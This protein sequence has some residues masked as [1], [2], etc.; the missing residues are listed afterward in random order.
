MA[1]PISTNYPGTNFNLEFKI[2]SWLSGWGLNEIYTNSMVSAELARKSGYR[3]E[4]HLKIKNALSEDWQYLRRSLLP[5]HQQ[6]FPAFE[7]AH[8]YHPGTGKLPEEKLELIISGFTDWLKLKGIV[9]AL[10][11]KLHTPVDADYKPGA[12][13]IDLSS[14]LPRAKLYP[15]YRPLSSFAPVIE[16]LTFTL[17]EKTYIGPVIDTIKNTDKLIAAVELTETYQQNHTFKITYQSHTKALSSESITP[18]RK[19]IVDLLKTKFKTR[20]VGQLN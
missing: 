7:M 17:P 5:Q 3:L 19:K 10:A 4:E 6:N 12:A 9:D 11:A 13:V 14:L 2:K 15:H 20:L 8:T 1:S 16:D 18:L